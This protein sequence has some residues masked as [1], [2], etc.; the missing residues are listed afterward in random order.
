M[1]RFHWWLNSCKILIS[2]KI[3]IHI[4]LRHQNDYLC[5]SVYKAD[6]SSEQKEALYELLRHHSHSS[7]TA[8]VRRELASAKCRDLLATEP[9]RDL[10]ATE[11]GDDSRDVDMS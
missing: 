4:V 7:I 8:E 10:L 1:A 5:C 2:K 6:I 11:P 3:Y 9:S